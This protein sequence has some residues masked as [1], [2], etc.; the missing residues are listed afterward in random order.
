MNIFGKNLSTSFCTLLG[1]VV[2]AIVVMACGS[3]GPRWDGPITT[4]YIGHNYPV[5][6]ASFRDDAGDLRREERE[7]LTA[8]RDAEREV[9][10]RMGVRFE[11]VGYSDLMQEIPNGASTGQRFDLVRIVGAQQADLI[12]AGHIQPVTQFADIF[13][14]E[15]SAW[16]F[17]PQVFGHNF[18]ISNT[19]RIGP[20]APLVY[21]IGM[22]NRVPDLQEGGRTVLPVH[23][24]QQGRWTWSEFENYLQKVH[25]FHTAEWEGRVAWGADHR[26]AALLAIHAN[27]G[28]IYSDQGI[29]FASEE[30]IEAIA[31]IDR[32]GARRLLRNQ[33]IIAGTS[34]TEGVM[35][36]W[37]F[38]WGHY[39]FANLQNWLAGDMVGPFNERRERMGIVPFPRPDWREADDPAYRQANDARD[40]YAVPFNVDPE[41]AELAVRAFREYV[42]AYYR[43]L[44]GSNNALDYIN[45]DRG[46]RASAARL[47]IDVT[48]RD[49]GAAMMEAWRYLGGNL[50]INEYAKNVGLWDFWGSDVLGDSLY[51]VNNATSYETWAQTMLPAAQERIDRIQ[52]AV[53]SNTE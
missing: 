36:Q 31:F 14:D 38:Q 35:D 15:E 46:A 48:S 5:E 13:A 4:I 8:R 12:E 47:F 53:D 10:N 33:D 44:S 51:G 25:D 1:M 40:T 20:D 39:I 2:L 3:P 43:I 27:G 11:W 52:R 32:L 9:L 19:L 42:L 7:N 34:Q 18:F 21:N 49:Y 41:R 16:M 30:A 28:Y 50:Q 6:M 37:R 24:W 17:W 45:S 29:G 26:T 22:L 23:L